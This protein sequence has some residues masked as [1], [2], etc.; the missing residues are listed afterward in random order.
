MNHLQL[1][2]WKKTKLLSISEFWDDT[3]SSTEVIEAFEDKYNVPMRADMVNIERRKRGVKWVKGKAQEKE[4]ILSEWK[5]RRPPF[6]LLQRRT[7][8]AMKAWGR[9]RGIQEHLDAL[10]DN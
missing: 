5:M 3:L 6:T 2:K 1:A 4:D 10:A 7:M 9:P 8:K